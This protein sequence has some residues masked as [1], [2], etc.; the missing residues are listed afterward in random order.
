MSSFPPLIFL[1]GTTASGKTAVAVEVAR[2]CGAEIVNADAYQVY[3]QIP[4]LTAAP[5]QEERD[6]VPHHLVGFLDV[7]E[8]WDA[9]LHYEKASAAIADIQS[10]G[11]T[12]LVVG[13]SG[14]YL[15]FLSHGLSEA[16]PSTP[17]LRAQL[18]RLSLEELVER[19]RSLDPEGAA[20]TNLTNR[21]YVT[22][23][24]EIVQLGGKPLSHWQNN[25]NKPPRGPG[26]ALHWDTPVLDRRIRERSRFLLMHGVLEEIEALGDLSSLSPTSRKTLGLSLIRDHLDGKFTLQECEDL[27]TLRTRQYAKRQRTWLRRESWLEPLPCSEDL[28]LFSF[29]VSLLSR[30]V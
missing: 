4:L 23:N 30:L 14:L 17:E 21:R 16:P 19:L 20:A 13:G 25:W 27:L 9:T 12:A 22:R 11:K 8:P 28:T 3:K 10:R 29:A 7:T 2:Q 26:F 1:T 15:K 24:L 6:A 18:D 5:T